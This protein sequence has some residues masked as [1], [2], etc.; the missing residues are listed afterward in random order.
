MPCPQ[1]NPAFVC[2]ALAALCA[3]SSGELEIERD[4]EGGG[5]ASS[6]Q[7][8]GGH[9]PWQETRPPFEGCEAL[10][11]AGEPLRVPS[12]EYVREPGLV[13]L[14]GG[15][16]GVVYADRD[17][18]GSIIA[19]RVVDGAFGRWPPSVGEAVTHFAAKQL[20][21]GRGG[22]SARA[23]GSFALS[24]QAAGVYR[25]E[26]P[27]R[28]SMP[29]GAPY[30]FVSV[31]LEPA[32]GLG[33][34]VLR[35]LPGEPMRLSYA[36]QA[37]ELSIESPVGEVNL[38]SDCGA[39]DFAAGQSSLAFALGPRLGCA[40]DAP[41]QV[42]RIDGRPPAVETHLAE[43]GT[44]LTHG[45]FYRARDGYTY[46]HF[47][48][49][50][51]EV[52]L[53]H[54]DR[55]ARPAPLSEPLSDGEPGYRV[56]DITAFREGH[57][58]LA[59]DPLRRGDAHDDTV[60]VVVGDATHRT[61]SPKLGATSYSNASGSTVLVGGEGEGSILVALGVPEGIALARADC[62]PGG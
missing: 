51:A 31:W 35:Y 2:T 54:F 10:V 21:A 36:A 9:T 55:F 27:G 62:V 30:L 42:F 43:L 53:H 39:L 24:G 17:E 14:E 57:A 32:P 44:E 45:R 1:V 26:E 46:A 38:A 47:G 41:L 19:S 16:V 56:H 6:S 37:R 12:S 49:P 34:Y 48:G 59:S 25:F 3:C 28:V 7:S 60:R 13:P 4:G 50:R 58:W 29:E 8:A 52:V 5:G 33:A 15:R 22:L 11:W 61:R 40:S 20:P 23:D 18:H